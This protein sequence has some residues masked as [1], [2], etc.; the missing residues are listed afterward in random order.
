MIA[1]P[2]GPPAPALSAAGAHAA[3]RYRLSAG[4]GR[5]R[6]TALGHEVATAAWREHCWDVRDSERRA[7]VLSVVGGSFRGRTK[8]ALVDHA[9][10]RTATFT[11]GEPVSR[12]HIGVVADSTGRDLMLVKADGPTGLHVIDATGEL[13]ALTSRRRNDPAH[14]SDLL[15]TAAGAHVGLHLMLGVT[16]SLELLRAGALRSVA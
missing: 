15:L 13:L 10:R 7:V 5:F 2:P 16:L 12:A 6:W 14:G 8:V 9:A 1:H 3:V 11:A 4:D